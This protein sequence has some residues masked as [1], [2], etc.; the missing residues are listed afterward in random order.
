MRKFIGYIL[1]F[2]P[3]IAWILYAAIQVG[4]IE[5]IGILALIV[6]M[7]IIAMIGIYLIGDEKAEREYKQSKKEDSCGT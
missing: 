5:T 3:V 4:I 7:F 6:A 1:M 2:A